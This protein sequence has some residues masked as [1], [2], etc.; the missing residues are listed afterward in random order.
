MHLAISKIDKPWE[1]ERLAVGVG[2]DKRCAMKAPYHAQ[3]VQEII[4]EVLA[5][6]STLTK[7]VM[8]QWVSVAE[9][10]GLFSRLW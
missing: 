7:K 8:N 6:N 4:K 3:H 2:R 1:Y 9:F 10:I 5:L